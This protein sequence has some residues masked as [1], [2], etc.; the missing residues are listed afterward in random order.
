MY[1]KVSKVEVYDVQNKVDGIA[2]STLKLTQMGYV[3]VVLTTDQGLKGYGIIHNSSGADAIEVVVQTSIAPLIIGENPLS[4]EMLWTK[5]HVNL[6]GIGRKGLAYQAISGVDIALWDLKGKI[7]GLP[8]HRLLGS[9]KKNVPVYASGCWT[10]YSEET[11]LAEVDRYIKAGYT[12]MKM[13][14][15]VEGG[16]NYKEDLRR[17]RKVREFAG[18]DMTIFVDC[19]NVW[20]GSSAVRF[21]D[22]VHELDIGF[23]EEPVIADDL[24]GLHYVR[25]KGRI[26][27]ATGEHE[28]TKYGARDLILAKAVDVIQCNA[29]RV[30]GITEQL[31]VSA[32]AQAWNL[33]FAPHAA[34][35]V[36]RFVFSVSDTGLTVER[37]LAY[38][39]FI[40]KLF[41]NTP[42]PKNGFLEFREVPGLDLEPD[43]NFV[44]ERS[45][46]G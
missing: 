31:K 7:L 1:Q 30:G 13:K 36:N 22:A 43:M 19:N 46:K 29:T 10:S 5:M 25:M 40:T 11:L 6:R 37:L 20:D 38:E 2:D 35:L 28:Y 14:V 27:V 45:K 17:V 41:P 34:D 26:P 12:S 18:K 42:T 3:L 8:V 32:M 33:L 15:G 21:A 9:E 44:R 23:L 24:E 4:T 16:R 39:D